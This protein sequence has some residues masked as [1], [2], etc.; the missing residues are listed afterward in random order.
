[1]QGEG[2][3]E[4]LGLSLGSFGFF[5]EPWGFRDRVSV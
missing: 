2:I 5:A 3:V 4:S 1:M